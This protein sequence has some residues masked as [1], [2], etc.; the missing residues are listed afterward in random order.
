ML[1]MNKTWRCQRG[2]RVEELAVEVVRAQVAAL[3]LL[4]TEHSDSAG[5]V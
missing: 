1:G 5:L 3:S 4:R 2:G